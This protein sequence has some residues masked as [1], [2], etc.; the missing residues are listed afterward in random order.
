LTTLLEVVDSNAS[1]AFFIGIS[2]EMVI[3]SYLLFSHL[4]SSDFPIAVDIA[5]TYL[6]A[7]HT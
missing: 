6:A 7:S 1:Q 2:C 5:F 3:V 4:V